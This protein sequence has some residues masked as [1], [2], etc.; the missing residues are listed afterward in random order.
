M[1]VKHPPTNLGA[2]I[3]IQYVVIDI[4][5]KF[6]MAAAAIFDLFAGAMGPP[7]RLIRGVKISSWP[8]K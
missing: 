3:Y 6:N 1:A 5:P 2:Q 4:F 7:R 8:A